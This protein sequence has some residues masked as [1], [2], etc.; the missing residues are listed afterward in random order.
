MSQPPHLNVVARAEPSANRL[1]RALAP[2]DLNLLAAHFV[3]VSLQRSDV[4][5]RPNEPIDY[6]HFM[7]EGIC[8]VVATTSEG[9]RIEVG[10]VGRDGMTGSSVLLGSDR[11]PHES[12]VQVAG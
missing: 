12:F 11:S 1:L 9:R 6:I 3:P 4:L 2:D 5:I 8:S 10:I 7:V